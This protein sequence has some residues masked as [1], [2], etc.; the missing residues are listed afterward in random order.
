MIKKAIGANGQIRAL[1]IDST[2]IVNEAQKICNASPAAIA[3]LGRALT[4]GALMGSMLKNARDRLSV[5]IKGDG[6]LGGIVVCAE[7][8]ADFVGARG[9]AH[10]PEANV[11]KKPNGK[12][13]VSGIVGKGFLAVTKDLGLKEPYTGRVPLISGEIAEDFAYYYSASEQRPAAVALGVLVD[14]DL[15]V[16]RAGGFFLEMLPGAADETAKAL[17]ETLRALPP[18]TSV[19]EEN[20]NLDDLLKR[21]LGRWDIQALEDVPAKYHCDCARERV[22]RALVS[23]GEAELRGLIAGKD[24]T[25]ITCQFCPKTYVFI[26]TD[27]QALLDSSK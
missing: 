26:K 6:P 9:Y 2:E 27:L 13:D 11:P 23:L 24:E 8:A 5:F 14:V 21:L 1:V 4:M 19:L 18:I 25:E 7:Y 22:E 10:H 12:L 16:K 17:S 15:S 3:A 20:P